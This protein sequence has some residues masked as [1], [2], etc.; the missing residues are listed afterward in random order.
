MA[1]TLKTT[2]AL[3]VAGAVFVSAPAAA[4]PIASY[5]AAP[6]VAAQT[7][8][9]LVTEVRRGRKALGIGLGVLGAAVILNEA[10]KAEERAYYHD[11]REVYAARQCR[12]LHFLCE[13]G[14]DRA[15]DRFDDLC[16]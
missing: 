2:A 6:T 13:D 9:T 7:G 8:D 11:R 16:E 5:S 14:D 15:C 12:R 10:A 1:H 4:S 3:L